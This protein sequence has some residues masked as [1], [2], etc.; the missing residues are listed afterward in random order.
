[1]NSL[2]LI[3]WATRLI[4]LL[5][6]LLALVQ[7]ARWV[8][9][10]PWFDFKRVEVR[11]DVRHVTSAEL[12]A[13]IAGRLAGNYFTLRLDEA[14]RAVETVPW[15]AQAAVRRVWPDLMVVE[16]T[17][18]R[19][20]GLWDD[21]RLVSD[22]GVL[23]TAN[24]AEAEVYGPLVEFGGPPALAGEAVRRHAAFAAA[25]APLGHKVEQVQVS[26][27]QS[28]SLATDAPLQ[29]QL[30]RDEPPGQVEQRLRQIVAA[31]PQLAAHSSHP[32][33]RIDA[34]YPNGFAVAFAP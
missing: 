16:L 3:Q 20:L 4:V 33:R 23:F 24:P 31:Y 18:H 19:A 12:R 8:A 34:R 1:M 22:A 32:P 30:G 11:G 27:R 28:W 7:V 9:Q 10:R 14:R 26:E 13:A 6:I 17:E 21:G 29:V 15:V 25:L 2:R 5:A